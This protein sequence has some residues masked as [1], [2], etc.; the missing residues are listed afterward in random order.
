M[1]SPSRLSKTVSTRELYS[2]RRRSLG[3]RA[4]PLRLDVPDAVPRVPALAGSL[5]RTRLSRPTPQIDRATPAVW[6]GCRRRGSDRLAARVPQACT[7]PCFRACM[8]RR[9]RHRAR[10]PRKLVRCYFPPCRPGEESYTVPSPQAKRRSTIRNPQ[11]SL[12]QPG[13]VTHLHGPILRW[14]PQQWRR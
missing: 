3:R 1:S 14:P 12:S 6:P 5:C 7:R 8:I 2:G 10:L 11:D 9:V 13:S 4:R